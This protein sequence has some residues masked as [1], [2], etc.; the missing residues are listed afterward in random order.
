MPNNM[1]NGFNINGT[2][3]LYNYDSLGNKLEKTSIARE[4]SNTDTYSVN[5]YV[6][7]NGKMYRCK[8]EILVGE[9]FDLTKWDECSTGTELNYIKKFM[10]W[11]DGAKNALLNLLAHVAYID[12]HGQDYYDALEA[13]L[14]RTA[15]LVSISAVFEQGSA[16]IY[17]TD[18]LDTLK[19]YLTVTATYEDLSTREIT[20][21]TLSG[22]LEVGTST[23]T[24]SYAGKTTTFNVTVTENTSVLPSAYQQVEWIE[25][26]HG[27]VINTEN[28]LTTES[29]IRLG[30]QVVGNTTSTQALAV[31]GKTSPSVLFLG[32]YDTSIRLM[33]YVNYARSASKTFDKNLGGAIHDYIFNK[34]ECKIDGVSVITFDGAM[35]TE[36]SQDTSMCIF[37]Y[38]DST[39]PN[40]AY[41]RQS[42]SRCSYFQIYDN[43]VLVND[44][45]PCYRKSDGVIG[46]Y[47]LVQRAFRTN[48]GTGTFTKG[49]DVE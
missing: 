20:A 37:G 39:D 2:P 7:Y 49:A 41:S 5:E 47:D 30:A 24:V 40:L 16:V 31:C 36:F 14:F 6:L 8:Q 44:L 43:G 25:G 28:R 23:I 18:D 33:G 11:S 15:D 32:Y 17:D 46:M 22:T 34:S 3:V 38:Q 1:V 45:V 27:P 26:K 4:Y 21:Y 12:E 29:E 42:W 35:T 10:T 19:Q 9:T 48:V 13:E